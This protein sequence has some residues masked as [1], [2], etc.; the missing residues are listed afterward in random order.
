MAD[1][2]LVDELAEHLA[3]RDGR[4]S[5]FTDDLDAIERAYRDEYRRTARVALEW[6]AERGRLIP[7]GGLTRAEWAVTTPR[8]K[9]I[10]PVHDEADART[11]A[12][13]GPRGVPMLRQVTTWPDG[14]ALTTPWV[15]VQ[16]EP[17]QEKTT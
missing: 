13:Y 3:E 5:L 7:N 16:P 17:T 6:L 1:E 14:T 15:A 10:H 11:C 8:G 4:R 12:I 9:Q 2:K